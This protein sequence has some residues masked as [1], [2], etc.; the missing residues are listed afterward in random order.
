M[1]PGEAAIKF[2]MW[3]WAGV[4]VVV[5]IG[6]ITL[7][8]WAAGWW[9]TT[10]NVQRAYQ[11]TRQSQAY[12]DTFVSQTDKAYQQLRADIWNTAQ[13]TQQGDQSMVSE[14]NAEIAS[15]TNIFCK[16]AQK[17]VPMSFDSLGPNEVAFYNKHC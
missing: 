8:G 5:L 15:D 17:L 10:Q 12:Q 7:G 14:G 6:G 1:G 16:D 13:A 3:F 2:W 4:I 9:F 11:V